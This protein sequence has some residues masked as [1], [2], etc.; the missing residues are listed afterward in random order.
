[1]KQINIFALLLLAS[2]FTAIAGEEI[3]LQYPNTD[4]KE[5]IASYQR[6]TGK[7]IIYD[8]T[9]QGPINVVSATP[10]TQEKA[11]ELIEGTLFADGFSLADVG[12]DSIQVSG[13]GRNSRSIGIPV[14]SKPED[15]PTG[16]RVFIY[17][18]KLQ[19][20]DAGVVQKVLMQQIAPTVYTDVVADTDSKTVI[21][22]ERTSVIRS[23]LK[24]VAAIDV[25]K[26]KDIIGNSKA[27][28][29]AAPNGSPRGSLKKDHHD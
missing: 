21:V 7:K 26:A 20:R 12:N 9:V 4:V 16:E 5:I 22:T 23:L 18:I 6:I 10:V 3:T 28:Q 17:I 27:E 1:M 11:I 8:N 19:Y 25:P 14:Y 29:G 15:I 13:I 24:I 2:T